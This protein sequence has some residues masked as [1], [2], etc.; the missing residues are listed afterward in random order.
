M[1]NIKGAVN[2]FI[3]SAALGF[4]T[5][6]PLIE[7]SCRRNCGLRIMGF[8]IGGKFD[9]SKSGNA[10]TGPLTVGQEGVIDHRLLQKI[11]R[12]CIKVLSQNLPQGGKENNKT[13]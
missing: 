13:A 6:I 12:T 11:I 7:P 10:S 9:Q 1:N 3:S 5:Y 4:L 2:V 8:F